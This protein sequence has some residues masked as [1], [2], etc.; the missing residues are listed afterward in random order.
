MTKRILFYL[1]LT[2]AFISVVSVLTSLTTLLL[3][4]SVFGMW[5][6]TRGMTVNEINTMLGA[7]FFNKLF[8]TNSFTEDE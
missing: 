4:G 7:E 2:V 3:F 1:C 5:Y 6:I 8:N